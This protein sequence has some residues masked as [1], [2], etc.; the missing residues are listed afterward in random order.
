MGGREHRMQHRV[1]PGP[2]LTF[3]P[4]MK[5]ADVARLLNLRPS[6]VYELAAQGKISHVRIGRAVRF[7]REAL[8]EFVALHSQPARQF[9]RSP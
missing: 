9:A 1:G 5:A 7:E 2:D 8:E 6:T 3:E 4:L